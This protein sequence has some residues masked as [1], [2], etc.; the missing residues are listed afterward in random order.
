MPGI[1]VLQ[2][3]SGSEVIK[4]AF[5]SNTKSGTDHGFGLL[6]PK[7]VYYKINM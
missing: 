1:L 3:I 7:T 6:G 2:K 5:I 4:S